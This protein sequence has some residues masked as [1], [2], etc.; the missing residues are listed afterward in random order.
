M[1]RLDWDSFTLNK[2][3]F[4]AGAERRVQGQMIKAE[5][6]RDDVWCHAVVLNSG[7]LVL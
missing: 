2:R 4:T 3:R 7:K 1:C 6:A 5:P